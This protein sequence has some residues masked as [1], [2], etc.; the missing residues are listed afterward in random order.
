V[1]DLLEPGFY[2][3]VEAAWPVA[4]VFRADT[5]RRKFDLVPTTAAAAQDPRNAGYDLLPPALR[6]VWDFVVFVINRQIVGPWLAKAFSEQISAR[7]ELLQ[8]AH[9]GGLVRYSMAGTRGWSYRANVGRFMMRGNGYALKPHVDGAPYLV[10][11]LMYFPERGQDEGFGTILYTPTRPLDFEMVVKSGSTEYFDEAGIDCVETVR[12]PYRPNTLLAFPN[13]LTSAH[14]V[15]SPEHGYRR[16]FQ[17][18][19][20]LKGDEEKV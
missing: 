4:E 10:T 18:H 13:T 3:M 7:L 19:L 20:S 15:V 17:Y 2:R 5:R 12:V 1:H 16:V 11:A 8:R 6:R 14:G 9:A